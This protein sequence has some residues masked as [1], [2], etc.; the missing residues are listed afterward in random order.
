M[1]RVRWAVAG[2]LLALVIHGG[3][4][5]GHEFWIAPERGR[6]EPGEP[7]RADLKVG[8]RL[9]G[10]SYP[11]RSDHF[12][13]FTIDVGDAKSRVTGNDGD[14]PALHQTAGQRGLHVISLQTIPF[15]VTYEDFAQFRS[16]LLEEGLKDFEQRH[17]ARGLPEAGFAERYTRY[18][19]ALVQV[20]PVLSDDG[21]VRVG[22]PMELIAEA[23]PYEPGLEEL[24]VRLIWQDEPLAQRQINVLQRKSDGSVTRTLTLTDS[25]GRAV[26]PLQG[27]ADILLNAVYLEAATDDPVVWASHWASLFFTRQK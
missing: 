1:R 8:Q 2:A 26:I 13:V 22:M 5:F 3:P 12:Q 21:D 24:Q 14:I 27:D 23:N 4:S 9:A 11:Y 6:L 17:L 25:A 10:K 15:R 20:G 19:K 16:F 7:I 18:A